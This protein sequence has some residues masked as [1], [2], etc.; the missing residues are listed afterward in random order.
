MK[1]IEMISR[2]FFFAG[3]L[4]MFSAFA[5]A[6]KP[7][8]SPAP[9]PF[10]MEVEDVFSISGV[11]TIATG[12]VERGKVKAGDTVELVG[13]RASATT[14]VVRI[15]ALGKTINEAEKGAKIGLLLKG[16]QKSDVT[17]GQLIV[18]PGSVSPVTR[19]TAT[20]DM[21]EIKDGGRRT[22]ITSTFRPQVFFRSVG[23]S[24]TMLLGDGRQSAAAGEKGIRV[25]I[26][27]IEP[28]GIETGSP[29]SLRDGGRTI[30]TGKITGIVPKK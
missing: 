3:L 30:A 14:T 26:E 17:R 13:I 18:K 8:P 29:V 9:A 11:G 4:T 10:L 15:D 7:S 24:G 6:Q 28:A 5:L 27:L 12:S 2:T 21:I 1:M 23:F 20:I 25:E 19:F 22:P 16:L